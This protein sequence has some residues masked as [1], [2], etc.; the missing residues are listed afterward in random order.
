MS[1]LLNRFIDLIGHLS[2]AIFAGILGSFIG[3]YFF[4]L[5]KSA[6]WR[7][8]VAYLGNVNIDLSQNESRHVK[9]TIGV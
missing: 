1:E 9:K 5:G 7:K 8:L 6:I 2:I 3:G 4:N